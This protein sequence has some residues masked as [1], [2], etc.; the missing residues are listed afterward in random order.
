[1]DDAIVAAVRQH[2]A[3]EAPRECCGVVVGIGGK[4]TYRPCR[5]VSKEPAAFEIDALDWVTAEDAGEI[6]AICHS[7]VF[8]SPRPS[9]ADLVECERNGLPWLIVNHPTGA[10][11]W[12]RPSGYQAPL[13][14][15]LFAHGV[16]DCYT[17]VR[18]WYAR[19]LSIALP[20]FKRAYGWWQFGE[21]L[22]RRH[23]REAGFEAIDAAAMAPHDVVLMAVRSPDPAQ[24]NHAAVYI[25][26]QKILQHLQ[27]RLSSRDVYGGWYRKVTTHVLRH[28]K[29]L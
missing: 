13:I 21:D 3:H 15:R 1:M 8:V 10:F 18:D 26:Q 11:E 19:E 6:L 20:D 25:G 2:A 4:Q 17:I 28:R 7:H 14:G 29:F 16:L 24:P 22:Y 23:F 27:G 9:Q 12:V 5:N